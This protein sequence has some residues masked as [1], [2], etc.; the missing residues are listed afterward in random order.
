MAGDVSP[1]NA[2]EQTFCAIAQSDAT[3]PKSKK[4]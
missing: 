2:G 4:R 3:P 1:Q